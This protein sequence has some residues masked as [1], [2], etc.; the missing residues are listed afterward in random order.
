MVAQAVDEDKKRLQPHAIQRDDPQRYVRRANFHLQLFVALAAPGWNGP[1]D[2]TT[3]T[4][5]VE[6]ETLVLFAETTIGGSWV[7]NASD[8]NGPGV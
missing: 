3:R 5:G 4:G 8:P 1:N 2:P 7:S 6:P